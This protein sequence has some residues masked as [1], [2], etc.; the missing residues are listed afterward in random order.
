MKSKTLLYAVLVIFLVAALGGGLWLLRQQQILRSNAAPASTLSLQPS[1][2]TPQIDQTFTVN[3][4]IN[5]GTN[6]VI[7]TEL[8]ITFDKTKLEATAAAP[9]DFFVGP[10]E[11]QKNLDNDAGEVTYTL[12]LPTGSS[13]KTGSGTVAILTFK[14]LAAGDADIAFKNPD[15]IIGGTGEGGQNVL[16]SATDSS[17]T[18]QSAGGNPTP[19][20]TTDPGGNPTP[21]PTTASSNTTA[22]PTPTTA[23]TGSGNTP[24]PTQVSSGGGGSGNGTGTGTG[25][26]SGGSNG[27]GTTAT[28]SGTQLPNTATPTQTALGILAGIFLIVISVFI[29]LRRVA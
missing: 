16:V 11:A 20:P 1:N 3:V 10:Q 8:H 25:T 19:T 9:G 12:Y 14:A 22:T 6:T 17:V 23:G 15:T 18:V 29:K 5:T 21:T 27:A 28:G 13:P 7:G 24:T 26:G 2:N 4:D